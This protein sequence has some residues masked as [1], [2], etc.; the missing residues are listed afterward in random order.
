MKA[1]FLILSLI[2]SIGCKQIQLRLISEDDLIDRIVK[3]KIPKPEEIEIFDLNQHVISLDSAKKLD[4]TNKYFVN[5]YINSNDEIVRAV[6]RIKTPE[7]QKFIDKINQKINESDEVKV[8]EIDCA[9]KAI[10]L[11]N[12]FDRDQNMRQQDSIIDP[13]ID[14]QNLEIVV[15]LLEKCGMPTLQEVDESQMAGI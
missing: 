14:H 7:D 3:Q 6:Y 15:S 5:F 10:I 1:F 4:V 12:V 8:V 13:S 2:F 11:Q 9:K